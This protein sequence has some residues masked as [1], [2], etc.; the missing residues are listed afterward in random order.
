[1]RE[2]LAKAKA[3]LKDAAHK[4]TAGGDATASAQLHKKSIQYET[5]AT[6]AIDTDEELRRHLAGKPRRRGNA[7]SEYTTCAED[8]SNDY[9]GV[10]GR[11]YHR[12]RKSLAERR[13]RSRSATPDTEI[14]PS[15]TKELMQMFQEC[16]KNTLTTVLEVIEKPDKPK[17]DS[18]D[19]TVRGQTQIPTGTNTEEPPQETPPQPMATYNPMMAGHPH[20]TI[21]KFT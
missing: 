2:E 8:H 14:G 20:L 5:A 7:H 1:M 21:S 11:V 19:A 12:R 6:S 17:G 15:G 18:T 10:D 13:S 16:M 3:A 9:V 4:P